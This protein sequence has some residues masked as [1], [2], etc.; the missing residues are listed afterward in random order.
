MLGV[1]L[2][3]FVVVLTVPTSE[4]QVLQWG[5][6]QD[7][8]QGRFTSVTQAGAPETTATAPVADL[9]GHNLM[10]DVGEAAKAQANVDT[11]QGAAAPATTRRPAAGQF[12]AP[13]TNPVSPGQSPANLLEAPVGGTS[14][15]GH[16]VHGELLLPARRHDGSRA[17]G[18]PH[19]VER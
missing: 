4:A 8:Q 9:P 2:A 19:G 18:P 12:H 14:F 13:G 5:P 16:G 7:I 6:G 3:L 15:T 10:T 11:F 17:E 1:L